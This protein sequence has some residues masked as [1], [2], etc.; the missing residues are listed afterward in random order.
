MSNEIVKTKEITG[1]GDGVKSHEAQVDNLDLKDDGF[2]EKSI[3]GGDIEERL[4]EIELDEEDAK[5]TAD[6]SYNLNGANSE[7]QLHLF[8]THE[9]IMFKWNKS[10]SIIP[11]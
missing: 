10:N 3:N 11:P 8:L 6:V 7:S 1:N 9:L 5:M 4:K 2:S